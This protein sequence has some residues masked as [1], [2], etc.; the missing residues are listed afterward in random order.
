MKKFK[1][2]NINDITLWE[3]NPRGVDIY[4]D[5]LSERKIIDSFF[6]S[7]KK[8]TEMKNL[9]KDI[10]LNGLNPI[11]IVCIWY[12]SN[13][14]RYIST[15]G[16]RRVVSLKLMFNPDLIK[17]N[18]ELYD[19]YSKLDLSKVSDTI[20]TYI[21]EDYNEALRLAENQHLGIDDGR[22]QIPWSNPEKNFFRDKVAKNETKE[23][24]DSYLLR[25]E[26]REL[27]DN[28]IERLKATSVDRII[29]YKDVK[30]KFKISDYSRITDEQANLLFLFLQTAE[31]YQNDNNV[32]LSRFT[33]SQ[34]INVLKI[35]DADKKVDDVNPEKLKKESPLL[36]L[37]MNSINIEEKQ[38]YRL[39]ENIENR[40]DFTKIT[41]EPLDETTVIINDNIFSA[42]NKCGTHS[43]RIN[44]YSGNNIVDTKEITLKVNKAKY[45]KIVTEI[46]NDHTLVS[47]HGYT[48]SIQGQNA[49]ITEINALNFFEFSNVITT[50]LRFLVFESISIL[51]NTKSWPEKFD[52]LKD[53][54]FAYKKKVNTDA[55]YDILKKELKVEKDQIKNFYSII[56]IDKMYKVLNHLAHTATTQISPHQILSIAQK[57][58]SN[59]LVHISVLI[60]SNIT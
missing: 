29:G 14:V 9:A 40:N 56:D 44:G 17:H 24:S 11:N 50:S 28:I 8:V 13:S 5:N 48:I 47:K 18:E 3:K 37:K 39:T 31:K 43:V 33:K 58:I 34:A 23:I 38:V 22:G 52:N 53:A 51:F 7:V 41:F 15:D 36:K 2:L 55:F 42:V 54:L 57:E 20:T 10:V 46:E 45:K 60:K 49:L 25:K 27:F 30:E 32:R 1:S 59:L 16:N 19:F 12:D 21:T 6:S 4:S 35:M 26:R